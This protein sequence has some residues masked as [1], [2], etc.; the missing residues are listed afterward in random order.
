MMPALAMTLSRRPTSARPASSARRSD[1][2]SRTSATF[3]T[4]RLSSFSTCSTVSCRSA[5][6]LMGYPTVAIW[7]QISTAIMSAPSSA[8]RKAWLRPWPR[9]APVMKATLPVIRLMWS[10]LMS[11]TMGGE[12][13]CCM[14]AGT[15]QRRVDAELGEGGAD[16]EVDF[17]A[18][19][20]EA[21]SVRCAAQLVVEPAGVDQVVA[22]TVCA[23][24]AGDQ[25]APLSRGIA[26]DL[27]IVVGCDVHWFE[28]AG[29]VGAGDE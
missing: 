3:A 1:A 23:A 12:G 25:P 22:A 13:S 29:G 24:H 16:A 5:S 26:G 9:A 20:D 18:A 28:V 8:R 19:P 7:S 10:P 6:V 17:G 21:P 11:A 15:G 14:P 4:M 27:Y 2:G